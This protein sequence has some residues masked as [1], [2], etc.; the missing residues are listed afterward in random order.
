[1]T[2]IERTRPTPWRTVAWWAAT[3]AALV[4]LDDLT[5]GPVF[6][7]C[8]RVV[9]PHR[10]GALAFAIYTVAQVWIVLRATSPAPG[11]VA[12]FFVRRLTLDRRNPRVAANEHRVRRR[13]VGGTS[14]V[15]SSLLIGGVLPP[16]LLWRRSWERPAVLRVAAICAPLYAAEFAL[17]HGILPGLP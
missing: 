1:V 11:R 16:L 12:A 8:A 14:A 3:V 2:A 10:A 6:W 5:V 9:G 13:V 4:V 7:I 17:L 15:A